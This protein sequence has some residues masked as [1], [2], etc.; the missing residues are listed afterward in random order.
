MPPPQR[1]LRKKPQRNLE[2]KLLWKPSAFLENL[3]PKQEL[4]HPCSACE[5]ESNSTKIWQP[6][7]IQNKGS[8]KS[9]L[10]VGASLLMNSTFYMKHRRSWRSPYLLAF[11]PSVWDF[12]STSDSLRSSV[13]LWGSDLGNAVFKVSTMALTTICKSQELHQSLVGFSGIRIRSFK[14]CCIPIFHKEKKKKTTQKKPNSPNFEKGSDP[15]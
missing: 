2:Q 4:K 8:I 5:G 12:P 11:F 1:S 6:E 13:G 3:L 15:V 14:I 7:I 10:H 9:V